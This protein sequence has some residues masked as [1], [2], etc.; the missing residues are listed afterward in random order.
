MSA[1][2][3]AAIGPLA[4]STLHPAFLWSGLFLILSLLARFAIGR[5]GG[6]LV[7]ARWLVG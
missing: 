2:V 7:F 4:I 3:G 5:P 1:Q 6:W